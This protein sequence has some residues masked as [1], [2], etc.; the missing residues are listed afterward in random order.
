MHYTVSMIT[1]ITK[2][3]VRPVVRNDSNLNT[4]DSDKEEYPQQNPNKPEDSILNT[5]KSIGSMLDEWA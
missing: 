4:D 2:P 1:P 5:E 3:T